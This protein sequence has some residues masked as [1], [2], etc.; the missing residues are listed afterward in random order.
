[1]C[2][3]MLNAGFKI[4]PFIMNIRL[5]H[6]YLVQSLFVVIVLQWFRSVRRHLYSVVDYNCT[7]IVTEL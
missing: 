4:E 3:S 1:M 2:N 5:Q 6:I 7:A